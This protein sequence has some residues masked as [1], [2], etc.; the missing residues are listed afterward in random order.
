MVEVK[1]PNFY[2]IKIYNNEQNFHGTVSSGPRQRSW[3]GALGNLIFGS[4]ILA[5]SAGVYSTFSMRAFE[6]EAPFQLDPSMARPASFLMF[7]IAM[8]FSQPALATTATAPRPN[9]VLIMVDDMGYSDLGCYGGEIKTP[10]LDQLAADGL[11]F[12][13][14]YNCAKCETTRATL[15]SGRYHTDV[16]VGQLK[17]CVTIAE[18]MRAGG[19][20]TLMT[21]KWHQASTPIERGFDHYFGHLSGAT[22]FFTG[23]DTFRLDDQPFKVPDQ[24]F[25]T[26]DANTDYAIK[27]LQER[28]KDK[29]F[30]LYLAFNAP[31]YPLQAPRKE[32]EKYRGKYMVGWDQLRKSR[33]ARIQKMGLLKKNCQPAPRPEDVP[34]WATLSDDEKKQH[35]LVM[36]TYAGMIDRV[37]QNIG[38]LVQKLK[39]EGRWENTLLM[40]LSDN[41]ACPFQRTKQPTL[42]NNIMP[43]DAASYWTYDKCWAHACNTP[44]REYKQNQ[45]EGGISTP[46]IAHWPAGVKQP[47]TMSRQPGHLVDIMA[48]CLDLAG[49]TYPENW[50]GK[51]V[52]P[53]R[54]SSLAP[55]FAGQQRK[56]PEFA[57][58]FYGKNNAMRIG[59]WKLVNINF[60]SWELYDLENDR[61]ELHN[62]AAENGAQLDFMKRRWA[63]AEREYCMNKSPRKLNAKRGQKKKQ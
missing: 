54:G 53:P 3:Q 9:I 1:F 22:N 14:F 33:F 62:L 5:A 29:P 46:L 59:Q 56:Q 7:L 11:R 43:W 25:Y 23:D 60:G 10:N 20:T 8:L 47:G 61:T 21:G 58:T 28:Q 4:A 50:N 18:A 2:A 45:H 37:D 26:T 52:G 27:F 55:I 41:G 15:L 17:N 13:E 16:G 24:G 32:V 44:F 63:E 30:F 19:Y 35:D 51:P 31:H 57:F 39:N 34:A 49:L 40:F 42:K 38:R 48:T 12:T 6:H 36:A